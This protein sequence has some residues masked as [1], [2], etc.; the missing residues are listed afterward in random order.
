M[1]VWTSIAH[2]WEVVVILWSKRS[3]RQWNNV[4]NVLH[5]LS[6]CT[7]PILFISLIAF[8]YVWNIIYIHGIDSS[9]PGHVYQSRWTRPAYTETD[10]SFWRNFRHRPTFSAVTK[11]SLKWHFCFKQWRGINYVNATLSQTRSN[12]IMSNGKSFVVIK[13]SLHRNR[14]QWH[15]HLAVRWN[16]EDFNQLRYAKLKN[17]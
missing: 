15:R 14:R 2:M 5:I 13:I 17:T 16:E 1:G 9:C 3:Q 7:D 8:F 12:L 10:M 6:M 4:V 11:I